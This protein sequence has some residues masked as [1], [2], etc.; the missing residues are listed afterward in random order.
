MRGTRIGR[1]GHSSSSA[2]LISHGSSVGLFPWLNQSRIMNCS[3]GATSAFT[4]VASI[5]CSRVISARL[6]SRGLGES[7]DARDSEGMALSGMLR[8]KRAPIIPIAGLS[9]SL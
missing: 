5:R 7:F 6:T 1:S 3:H 8:P 4:D 9:R 2:S